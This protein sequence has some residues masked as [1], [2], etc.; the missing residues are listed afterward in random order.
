M[1]TGNSDKNV[2]RPN[3]LLK[4]L[5]SA[6]IAAV[7]SVALVAAFA[8]AL[9]KQWLGIESISAINITVKLV[10]ALLAAL[11]TVRRCE[12]RA[13]LWGAAAGA[14]YLIIAFASFSIISGEWNFGTG[15]LTDAAMCALCGAV[16]GILKNL[17]G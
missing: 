14:M 6:L 7:I 8:F 12:S 4:A 5:R 1:S 11:F 10:C 2:K 15:L 3:M 17:K 13:W 9:T 16:V